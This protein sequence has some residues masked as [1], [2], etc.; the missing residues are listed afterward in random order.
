MLRNIVI[1]IDF[2]KG[3]LTTLEFLG[4]LAQEYPVKRLHLVHVLPTTAGVLA[5]TKEATESARSRAQEQLDALSVPE[6]IWTSREV[7]VGIPARQLTEAAKEIAADVIMVAGHGHGFLAEMFLGSVASS[8][9]RVAHCP[10][11]IAGGTLPVHFAN[12]VAAVDLSPV[13]RSVLEHAFRIG[14]PHPGLPDGA[15]VKVLSLFEHPVVRQ[16]PKDLLPRAVTPK[17]I[18]DLG[19]QHRRAVLEMIGRVK[20]PGVEVDVE[21]MSKAPAANVIVD[22]AQLISADLIVIGTSGQGAWHRMILGSTA[23]HVLNRAPCP[24]VVVPHEVPEGSTQD[25]IEPM[26]V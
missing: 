12:V 8:L 14:A 24:V 6:G 20:N 10:V 3:S 5:M 7:R 26:P 16:E 25:L 9:I 15:R 21:V 19:E 11:L 17:D 4:K 13:S 23:N 1:G 18:E 22:V 2:S